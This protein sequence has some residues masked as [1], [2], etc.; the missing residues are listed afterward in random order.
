MDTSS[1][2]RLMSRRM[3]TQ[4]PTMPKLLRPTV[5]ENVYEKIMANK[6]KQAA[7]YNKG[8]KNL[9]ELQKGDIVRF[10]PPGSSTKEAVKA[11]RDTVI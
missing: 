5:D 7:N 10:I 8:A 1:V 3:R 6:D 9:P 11:S 2:M 4:L